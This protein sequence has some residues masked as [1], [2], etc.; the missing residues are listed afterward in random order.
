MNSST[1]SEESC[2]RRPR[3]KVPASP[4]TLTPRQISLSLSGGRT[5]SSQRRALSPAAPQAPAKL[6][7]TTA[8]SR[9]A[10]RVRLRTK[11]DLAELCSG[12]LSI[13]FQMPRR[14]DIEKLGFPKRTLNL[15]L[16]CFNRLLKVT[17]FQM[18]RLETVDNESERN[19]HVF[20][21]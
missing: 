12:M 11:L 14:V 3:A 6:A 10:S 19:Y 18:S 16:Y 9:C 5:R 8:T 2:K 13:V 7:R 15:L 20:P 17:L 21:F 4:L 1:A